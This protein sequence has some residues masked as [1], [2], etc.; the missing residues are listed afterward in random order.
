ME[1]AALRCCLCAANWRAA[2]AWCRLGAP[3]HAVAQ[4]PPTLNLQRAV[5]LPH[6]LQQTFRPNPAPLIDLL[7]R[8]CLAP[9]ACREQF[10]GYLCSNTISVKI[11]DRNSTTLGAALG[12][13]ND[14]A[15]EQEGSM[16]MV[17]ALRC[18]ALRCGDGMS[19]PSGKG[20]ASTALHSWCPP[21][22]NPTSMERCALRGRGRGDTS[23]FFF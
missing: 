19:Q 23:K 15:A 3:S 1:T 7:V 6:A 14:L 10:N 5:Q 17:R 4:R 13:V 8:F 2:A 12:A 21:H 18:P 22:V 16:V 9:L 20:P 11:T